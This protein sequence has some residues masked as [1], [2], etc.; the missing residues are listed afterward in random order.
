MSSSTVLSISV[1]FNAEM[2][3][4]QYPGGMADML[5]DGKVLFVS[6]GTATVAFG[7]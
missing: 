5:H 2:L 3:H 6:G 7:K 4:R 1:E